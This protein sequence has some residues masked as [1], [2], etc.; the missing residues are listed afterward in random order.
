MSAERTPHI[1]PSVFRSD[2]Q[3]I[4]RTL[5]RYEAHGPLRISNGWSFAL[6][7]IQRDYEHLLEQLETQQKALRNI[8]VWAE[9]E[10]LHGPPELGLILGEARIALEGSSPA[11]DPSVSED[12]SKGSG[13]NLSYP[14][15]RRENP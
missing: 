2:L 6:D 15:S 12:A 4:R 14:A 9:Q 7:D 10:L 13:G 3:K 5:E 8:A 11:S 1:S